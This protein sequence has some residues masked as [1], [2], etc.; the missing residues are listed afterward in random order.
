MRDTSKGITSRNG[1]RGESGSIDPQLLVI[2]FYEVTTG[3]SVVCSFN[4]HM[5]STGA[6]GGIGAYE[7]NPLGER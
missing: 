1:R 4:L 6:S 5:G 3:G 2:Y 7:P